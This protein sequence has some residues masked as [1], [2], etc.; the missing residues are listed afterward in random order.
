[1]NKSIKYCLYIAEFF[2]G[3]AVIAIIQSAGRL[4]WPYNGMYELT[5]WYYHRETIIGNFVPIIL[6]IVIGIVV[7]SMVLGNIF[8]EK[9]SNKKLKL[10]SIYIRLII[11]TL[12]MTLTPIA[13]PYMRI[14]AMVHDVETYF[15]EF[16]LIQ[17]LILFVIPSFLFGSVTSALVKYSV[18][19]FDDGGKTVGALGIC[20]KIGAVIGVVIFALVVTSEVA[21]A[22]AVMYL[23]TIMLVVSIVCFIICIKQQAKEVQQ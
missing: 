18:K 17:C 3:M 9:S 11:A 4:F 5:R 19:S 6:T 1:M 8:G 20:N 7:V 13:V 16:G 10:N 12:W 23:S 22:T 21:S 15:I 14:Q 2:V